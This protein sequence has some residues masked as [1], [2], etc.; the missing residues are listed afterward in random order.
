MGRGHVENFVEKLQLRLILWLTI[1]G[2]ILISSYWGL[3]TYL[4]F[5]DGWIAFGLAVGW[6]GAA[7]GIGIALGRSLAKPTKYIADTILHIS[8]SQNLIKP[9]NIDA[10]GFGRE[11]AET[12]SRQVYAFATSA[13]ASSTTPYMLPQGMLDQIPVAVLGISEK[14]TISLANSKAKALIGS[15]DIISKPLKH[16]LQFFTDDEV[17]IESWLQDSPQKSLNDLRRW[18]KTELKKAD[19]TSLGYFDIAASFSKHNGSGIETVFVLF[20]HSDAYSQ[21]DNSLSFISLAVHE[22]RAPVTVMRGYIEAFQEEVGQNASPQISQDLRRMSVSAASLA[23]FITNILNVAKLNQGQLILKLQEENWNKILPQIIDTL[24]ERA[25]VYNKTLELRM[26][27][28]LPM[29]AIDRMTMAEVINNL[30]DN[31]VKYSPEGPAKIIIIS[32]QNQDRLIETTVQDFGCGI[33]ESVLPH[34]FSKFYRNHRTKGSV[35]GTGLGLFLSK[36]IVT[37]HNGNIWVRS[38]ENE[39]TT[40]GFTIMPFI[41]LD[42][43]QRTSDNEG[44]VRSSHGW[45]KNHSL[46]RR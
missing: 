38:K 39:G 16:T 31:A 24:R 6:V 21:E 41:Q 45:I 3:T 23:S 8:P 9:P 11:L 43:D 7:M 5:G 20:D 37:A 17:T 42:K 25:A 34:L 12:L 29:V 22:L 18:Q 28:E 14:G 35:G 33:P 2:L 44:I 19:N 15:K 32:K 13:N 46:Q 27:P 26:E 36:A 40:F 10:V 30:I 1:L 4:E